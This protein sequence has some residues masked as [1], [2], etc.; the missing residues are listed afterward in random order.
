MP[1]G[2]PCQSKELT[3]ADRLMIGPSR[4]S[5]FGAWNRCHQPLIS[6]RATGLKGRIRV[7]GDKSMSHRALMLGAVAIGETRIAGLLEAEDVLNTAKAMTA[8]GAAGSA[9]AALACP[10]GGCLRASWPRP[11][12]SISAIPEPACSLAMGLMATTPL[13]ARCIGDASL[14]RRPMGRVINPLQTSAC[15]SMPPKAEGCRSP[16][17]ARSMPCPSPTP[18][19]SPR[20]R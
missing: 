19:P 16:C 2:C 7:P 12:R 9:D 6:R 1:R 3:A 11:A 13:I 10:G 15:V 18:C 17:M 20:P 4:R 8:L 14:S 5:E